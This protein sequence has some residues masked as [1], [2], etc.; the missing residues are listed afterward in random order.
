MRSQHIPPA[1]LEGRPR[2]IEL[3]RWLRRHAKTVHPIELAAEFHF[4]FEN[5]HPFGE[6]NGRIGRLAMNILLHE[7]G[8]PMLNIRYGKRAGYYHAPERFSVRSDPSPF[9]LWF[10]RGYDRDGKRWSRADAAERRS[11]L[12]K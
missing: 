8:Y 3:L 2:L 4:R 11:S 6:G 10:F 12:S 1:P 9:L 7:S 5:I